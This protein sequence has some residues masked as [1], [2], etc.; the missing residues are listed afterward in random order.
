MMT[1]RD[2]GL[3]TAAAL[4]VVPAA[5]RA[6]SSPCATSKVAIVQ[7]A[8]ILNS[9]P[10]YLQAES[11]L[12]KDQDAYKLEISKLQGAL[13]SA[14][15]NFQ[16]KSALLSATQKTAEQRKLQD[17]YAQLQQHTTELEQKLSTRRQELIAPIE[18]RVQ[19]MI[20]GMRAEYGCAIIL[21]ANAQG[22][23]IASIDKSIDLTQRVI[24]RLKAAGDGPTTPA[25][26]P[27][28]I[29]PTGATPPKNP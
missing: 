15:A 24:D 16:D 13:D 19:D 21:D 22:S 28:G 14:G 5:A 1:R 8:M 11:L 26:K 3:L 12:V 29:K 7:G 20:D 2:A 25:A 27:P 9:M 18:Q 23:G 10:K 6:Q 4:L 17:Q